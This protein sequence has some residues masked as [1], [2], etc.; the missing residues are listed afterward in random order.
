MKATQRHS[1]VGVDLVDGSRPSPRKVD[2]AFLDRS[3]RC[4]FDEWS[5]DPTGAG[6]LEIGSAGVILAVDGPQGLAAHP[7]DRMRLCEKMVGVPGRC[8]YDLPLAGPY[9]GFISSSVRLFAS[10]W[11]CGRL[12]LYG[13][14]PLPTHESALLEVY[15]GK[16]W[17]DVARL[18]RTPLTAK[19]HSREGRQQRRNLLQTL[20]IQLP[21]DT[22]PAHDQLDAALAA[23]TAF[24]FS[25]GKTTS[26]G[27]P[28]FWDHSHSLLREGFIVYPES[29]M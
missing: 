5:F 14:P 25:Q 6:L 27:S 16:A 8:P 3:L 10:L 20:G 26:Q 21:P 28:P 1:F 19:K 29:I 15:P 12:H 17:R 22:V 13:G 9:A 4:A 11:Q 18:T 23:Y 7:G 2:I 24:L